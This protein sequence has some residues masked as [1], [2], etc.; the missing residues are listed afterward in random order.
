MRYSPDR[1]AQT[2]QRIIKEASARFRRD[3][4]SATGLQPLMKALNLTHGGFYAH[5][6]S[7]DELVEKALQAAA[8]ELDAHCEMLFSQERPLQAF[9][10]SYLSEWHL[11]SPDQ[12]CPLPTMSS[13]LGL[14]GQPSTTT[15]DVLGARLKQI[16]TALGDGRG[17]AQSL[18]MMSTLVGALVLARSVEN[19]ELSARIMEVARES[20]KAQIPENEKAGQ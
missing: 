1:K 12:G 2:H 5:F 10:D 8:A 17:D 13:E 16:E 14:R 3:G 7:K 4:I 11:T 18:V 19:T 15:D 20:L 9:I 6:K